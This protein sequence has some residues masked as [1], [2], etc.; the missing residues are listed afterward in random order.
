[1]NANASILSGSGTI[2]E[3]Q[4]RESAQ[5]K[6]VVIGAGQAGLSAA[7]T[8]LRKGLRPHTDFIVLDANEGPGGAWRHRW[9]SLTLG[10]AHGIHDLPGLELGTPDP[11]EP[12]SSVVA[13]YY[14]TYESQFGLP[15]V[16][17]YK[18]TGARS[19][20]ENDLTAPLVVS[21]RNAVTGEESDWTTAS[22]INATGTWDQPFWPYYPG[23]ETFA[24]RQLHTKDYCSAD[25][26]EGMRV[27]VVGGGASA[28]QFLIPLAAAGVY[29]V[30]STRRAPVFGERDFDSNWGIEVEKSV[31]E[32]TEAGLQT[33][34][35]VGATGLALTSEYAQ[36]IEQGVLISRGPIAR[37]HPDGVEFTGV[38]VEL[39]T[40]PNGVTP[41]TLPESAGGFEQVDVILWATGFKPAL[42]HLAPLGLRTPSGGIATD[43]TKVFADPRVYLAGYGAGASTIGATRTGRAAGA[44]AAKFVG[45]GG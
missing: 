30:W 32:R 29:T 2:V 11:M 3:N 33:L 41:H 37:I 15:I 1:M 12:A 5:L 39:A 43:G 35:V 17:P 25:E 13:R 42:R 31:R 21:A 7:A 45:V 8:L 14:G 4:G 40:Q 24:G 44:G 10:K 19:T 38:P 26:F 22:I 28:V 9:P 27:L 16:R 20:R 23:I 34:S 6:V 18:V 36:A